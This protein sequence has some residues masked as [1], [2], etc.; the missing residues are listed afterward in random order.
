F[1]DEK[2]D[3]APF[4]APS[5]SLPLFLGVNATPWL[6]FI[7]FGA[8]SNVAGIWAL[9][10][11]GGIDF[12]AIPGLSLRPHVSFLFPLEEHVAQAGGTGG[13]H[14]LWGLDFAFGGNRDSR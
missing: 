6:S 8:G 7:G 13:P 3:A 9:Q 5:V 11:G 2:E 1:S 10:A 4:L 14:V 12:S